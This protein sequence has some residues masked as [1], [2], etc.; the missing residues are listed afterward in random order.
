MDIGLSDTSGQLDHARVAELLAR[1]WT[2]D[3]PYFTAI[4]TVWR[5]KL[6]AS[7]HRG[8]RHTLYL[9]WSRRLQLILSV[10]SVN[11]PNRHRSRGN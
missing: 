8:P 7:W 10:G 3:R 6:Q 9:R 4:G 2:E 11:R 1:R 5:G